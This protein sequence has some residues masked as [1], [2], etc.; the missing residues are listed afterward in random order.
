MRKWCSLANR[1]ARQM[2]G[3]CRSTCIATSHALAAFLREQGLDA[4]PFRAEMHAHPLKREPGVYG[5]ILGSSGDGSR[6]PAASPGMWRGHLAVSCGGYVL[7]PTIDQSA[8]GKVRLRPAVF[9][10]P[11]GWDSGAAHCWEE[12]GLSVRYHLYYRQA[13]WKSSPDAR[14]SHWRDITAAMC[15][16]EA[17]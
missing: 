1:L 7:D 4:E 2:T 11:A 10:K 12:R 5:F 13:G 8:V 14:P 17:Q 15:A 3:G 6:Q 9:A 16:W